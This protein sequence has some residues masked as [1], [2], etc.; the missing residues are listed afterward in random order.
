MINGYGISNYPFAY[1]QAGISSR[2]VELPIIYEYFHLSTYDAYFLRQLLLVIV[3]LVLLALLASV[4]LNNSIQAIIA[5][6]IFIFGSD[7]LFSLVFEGM[8][9]KFNEDTGLQLNSETFQNSFIFQTKP[10]QIGEIILINK[11]FII[12]V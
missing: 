11:I 9:V 4:L 7:Q 1:L 12:C 2:S 5:M 6:V 8:F 10:C 3:A